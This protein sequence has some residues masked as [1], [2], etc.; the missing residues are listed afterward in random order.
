M[1]VLSVHDGHDG[2][3]CLIR[4]GKIVLHSSEERRNNVKN[5]RG[6]PRRSIG[7]LFE[8]TGIEPKDI[9]QVALVGAIRT[10]APDRK[11]KFST[12]FFLMNTLATLGRS[13]RATQFGRWLLPKIRKRKK[14]LEMLA[15]FGL[16]DVPLKRYDHHLCHA[17]CAYFHRPWDDD[18]LILTHDGAGDG[19]CATVNVGS[20]NE[21]RTVAQTPKFH[22]L[23]NFLYSG[24]TEHLGLKPWEHEYKIMG[25]APYGRAEF[26]MDILKPMFAVDGLHFRN[27]TG[28]TLRGL[29]RL[30]RNRLAGQRFDNLSA[31]CQ[32]LFEELTLQWV[33][34]ALNATGQ[35]KICAAGGAFLNVK[36]NALIRE[37]EAVDAFYAYPASDD[38]GCPIGG[39]ILG[40]LDLCRQNGVEPQFDLPRDM[41]LGLDHSEQEME[42]AIK[43]SSHS[44]RRMQDP[45]DEIAAMLVDGK[46]VARFDGREEVGPRAL[47]NRTILADPRDLQVIRKINFAIKQRDFWMPFAASILEEDVDRYMVN[48]SPWPYWMIEAFETKAEAEH[49]IIAGMH[50]FDKT[51]RPQVVNELNPGYRD[52]IRAFKKRTGVGA[53]LNTSFNLHGYPIVGSPEVAL[54]TLD[55]SDL[56]ALALGP[57]LVDRKNGRSGLTADSEKDAQR[58]AP[59]APAAATAAS[60]ASE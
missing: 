49:D 55:N 22:S 4:D 31:A 1:I 3:A 24:I 10:I 21:I 36:A 58:E 52:I 34:N 29:R 32:L 5:A 8:R 15:E 47:G 30:Y 12:S 33:H 14:L 57:F 42:Q 54:D 59:S 16:A 23:A 51:V 46:I 19:L 2:G 26:C 39:A 28:R 9:D 40:Y 48:P 6:V 50:P 18:A 13:H 56:D 53:V 27:R 17:A 43:R 44:Y 41:Y 20:G 7:A 60:Q 38:G 35:R 37:S 45:A 11:E 25:M